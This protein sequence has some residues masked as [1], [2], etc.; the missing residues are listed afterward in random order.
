MVRVPIPTY[1]RILSSSWE[2]SRTIP[3][4]YISWKALL[5][6]SL[7][8]CKRPLSAIMAGPLGTS[9]RSGGIRT[10]ISRKGGFLTS[11]LLKVLL[12][13]ATTLKWPNL[14]LTITIRML[15]RTLTNP[16]LIF[17][18]LI[19]RGK[20]L[21][22]SYACPKTLNNLADNQRKMARQSPVSSEVS[23]FI[24][25]YCREK[26]CSS[27]KRKSYHDQNS[28]SIINCLSKL[29]NEKLTLNISDMHF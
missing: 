6:C 10:W 3:Y 23:L 20:R 8:K 19:K 27:N 21:K 13:S 5:S 17:S 4:R 9:S 11:V 24:K 12:N 26:R 18:L 7:R 29:W 28:H 1:F 14:T 22:E 15:L 2:G 16:M 25:S